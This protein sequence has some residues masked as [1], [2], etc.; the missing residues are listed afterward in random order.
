LPV[1]AQA[2]L[3]V[4]VLEMW[5][6]SYGRVGKFAA[7]VVAALLLFVASSAAERGQPHRKKPVCTHGASSIG[8]IFLRAGKVVGGDTT[9]HTEACLP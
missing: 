4:Y 8:P 3:R 9:P 6:S 1:S 2:S 7:I 5:F